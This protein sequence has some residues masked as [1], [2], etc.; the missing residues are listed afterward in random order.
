MNARI[1]TH[2]ATPSASGAIEYPSSDGEPMAETDLHYDLLTEATARLTQHF[3]ADPDV[4][5]SGNLLV[6]YQEGNPQLCLSPDCFVAFGVEKG[7]RDTFKTWVEGVSPA[8][9]FEFT[10]RSTRDN[11]L[12]KKLAV[13]QDV[14]KVS[15][16]FLFD[17]R[18]EYLNP[19]LQGF[20][21]DRRGKLRPIA[22]DAGGGVFSE[23]LNLTMLRDGVMLTYR[24][25]ATGKLL[26]DANGHLARVEA[27]ARAE[28][29]RRADDEAT[30]RRTAEQVARDA[31]QTA[32]DA[33]QTARDAQ[34]TARAEAAARRD[35]EAR[36][37]EALAELARLRKSP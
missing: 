18:E 20:R 31:Q 32:R 11:D 27:E 15:E 19:S 26:T 2:P 16:Y 6:Y 7:R 29:E 14:W 4:Y 33:Q 17:P 28:A 25:E 24:D 23:R 12:V 30:A 21:R 10:S 37:A 8:V 5:V 35:A 36:L 34:Q 3:V 9:V 22:P 13:Y 1:L